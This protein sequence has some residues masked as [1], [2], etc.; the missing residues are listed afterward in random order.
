MSRFAKKIISIPDNVKCS[1]SQNQ[2]SFVS[3]KNDKIKNHINI[4]SDVKLSLSENKI[5]FVDNKSSKLIGTTYRLMQNAIKGVESGHVVKLNF[6]GVGFKV[7]IL[8]NMMIMMLG[9]SH[10]VGVIIPEGVTVV[11]QQNTIIFESN[12]LNLVSNF[13]NYVIKIVFYV[14]NCQHIALHA[15]HSSH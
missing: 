15:H 3:Q 5:S 4:H 6:S 9:F 12:D 13:A 8:G 11:V 10:L 7:N 14:N 1:M 2:L